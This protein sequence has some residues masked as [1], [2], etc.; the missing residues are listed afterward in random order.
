MR[1]IVALVLAACFFSTTPTFAAQTPARDSQPDRIHSQPA[2]API[3]T[4]EAPDTSTLAGT[5]LNQ[6]PWPVDRPV[7]GGAM[8]KDPGSR[9]W[10]FVRAMSDEEMRTAPHESVR[11]AACRGRCLPTGLRRPRALRRGPTARGVSSSQLSPETI[12]GT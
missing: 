6:R 2:I 11:S 8:R 10:H 4:P 7:A 12:T 1:Q 5:G 9:E 3:P